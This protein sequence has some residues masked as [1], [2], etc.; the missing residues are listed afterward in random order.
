MGECAF[1][2]LDRE[3]AETR[4]RWSAVYVL[5]K[6]RLLDEKLGEICGMT[7]FIPPVTGKTMQ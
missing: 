3:L 5:S 1:L 4:S 7:G 2:L 6:P